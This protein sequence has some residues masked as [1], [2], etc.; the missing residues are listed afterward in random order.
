MTAITNCPACSLPLEP[1]ES[2]GR[3]FVTL[4]DRNDVQ[5]I[6]WLNHNISTERKGTVELDA[7]LRDFFDVS[8]K[9]LA[10]W[11][12]VRFI[13]RFYGEKPHPF[14]LALQHPSRAVLLG[15]VLEH[16]HFLKQWARTL[17]WVVA[18][19]D[20]DEV[21]D[22]E[23]E[24]ITTEFVGYGSEKPSHYELL[25]RMGESLGMSRPTILSTPPSPV[26]VAALR[27]WQETGETRHW[28]ETMAA[29]HTLELVANRDIKRDGAAMTYFDP[30][31]LDGS[32]VTQ[33]TK[34]FLMEG[35]EADVKHS[36]IPLA[37][38]ERLAPSIGIVAD[39]Q[40]TVL[41]SIDAF[42]RYLSARLERAM[43]FE[44]GLAR[45]I[46]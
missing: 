11:I 41:R 4:S 3:H 38:V 28:L 34:E 9:G 21:L 20:L 22:L 13:E 2:L 15:Y 46:M 12:K 36:E 10:S 30:R 43:E 5:H 40:F 42:D 25:I 26:T 31:I 37:L 1:D 35:Y 24:N 16:Q 19:S 45:F 29:M 33:A 27:V 32:E 17:S 14:I 23:L 44:P 18:K 39:I 8:E 6:M 7:L